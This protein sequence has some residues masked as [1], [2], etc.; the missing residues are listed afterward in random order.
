MSHE[1]RVVRFRGADDTR[2][3]GYGARLHHAVGIAVDAHPETGG[4]DRII[5]LFGDTPEEERAANEFAAKTVFSGKQARVTYITEG[6]YYHK[7]AEGTSVFVP[8]KHGEDDNTHQAQYKNTFENPSPRRRN[9]K[10]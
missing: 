5:K 10:S 3:E 1:R 9:P 8:H 6:N 7:L 2:L 4:V